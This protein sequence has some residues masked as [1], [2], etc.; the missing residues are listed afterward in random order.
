MA[1]NVIHNLLDVCLRLGVVLLL[2]ALWVLGTT[3]GWLNPFFYGSPAGISGAMQE[4]MSSG[5]LWVD[6]G[7]SLSVLIGGMLVGT[8]MGVTLGVIFFALP[9]FREAAEP[10]VAFANGFPR[11]ILYPIF[12]L[13]LGFSIEAKILSVA[14]VI[15]FLA[16]ANTLAGLTETD[17]RLLDGVRIAGG[18]RWDLARL[19]Y[20]P[21]I[22]TWLSA[23]SRASVGLAFQAVIVTEMIGS[24]SGLG[25]MAAL[26]QGTFNVNIILA[27]VS[28]MVVVAIVID[29][30]LSLGE[31]RALRWRQP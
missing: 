24:A 29:L 28:V 8:A 6:L 4:W 30:L 14:L 15:I 21:S 1:R 9:L 11:L 5:Q 13:M 12:A 16:M 19:V 27:A 17:Q 10:V 22:F 20:I 2:I 23:G 26:G 3:T 7:H 25:H 31:K 18:G